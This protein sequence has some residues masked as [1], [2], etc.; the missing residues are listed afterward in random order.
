MLPP[1]R[2]RP[3][4][5][6]CIRLLPEIGCS[7]ERLPDGFLEGRQ[8]SCNVGT[9]MDAQD[10]ASALRQHPEVATRFRR[11]D[12][13]EGVFLPGNLNIAGVVAG[14]LQKHAGIRPAFVGLP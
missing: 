2:P 11:L 1:I 13:T 4:M 8:T 9:E 14:D 3:T 12:D 7:S 5:P 6:S 10:T